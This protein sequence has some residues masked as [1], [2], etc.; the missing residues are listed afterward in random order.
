[1][2]ELSDSPRQVRPKSHWHLRVE[3]FQG[4]P[5]LRYGVSSWELHGKDAGLPEG[6]RFTSHLREQNPEI[7]PVPLLPFGPLRQGQVQEQVQHL[8]Q[9]R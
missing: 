2:D 3:R 6:R 1:M 8:L 4:Q 7:E 9:V 5:D